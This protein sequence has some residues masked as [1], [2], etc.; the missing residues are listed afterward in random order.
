MR[1]ISKFNDY[2][3][4][5]R[6]QRGFDPIETYFAMG[7]ERLSEESLAD[8]AA[9]L[10]KHIVEL[11]IGCDFYESRPSN[12]VAFH[13]V[14]KFS[15]LWKNDKIVTRSSKLLPSISVAQLEDLQLCG[16]F[17]ITEE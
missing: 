1:R 9:G 11:S 16:P 10:P 14:K 7:W 17:S 15:F 4:D 5:S 3:M 6:L 13:H 12:N 2:E 8:L